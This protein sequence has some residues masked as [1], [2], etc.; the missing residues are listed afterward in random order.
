LAHGQKEIDIIVGDFLEF[1][2][3]LRA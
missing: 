3:A 2:Q 1:A